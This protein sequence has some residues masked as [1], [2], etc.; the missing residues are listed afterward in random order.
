MYIYIYIYGL[1]TLIQRE[2]EREVKD[3]FY[4]PN[5]TKPMKVIA[6]QETRRRI[7]KIISVQW[8][9]AG[10]LK[11]APASMV[12]YVWSLTPSRS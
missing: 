8:R 7:A 6:T 3:K 11:S 10:T 12:Y 5:D 9:L 1:Y 4:L 2:N